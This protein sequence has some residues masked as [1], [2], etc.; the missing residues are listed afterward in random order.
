MASRGSGGSKRRDVDGRMGGDETDLLCWLRRGRG[1]WLGGTL[2]QRVRQGR[3]GVPG[4]ETFSMIY[5]STGEYSIKQFM[6]REE[7]G[8]P[9]LPSGRPGRIQHFVVEA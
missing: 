4:R 3:R 6:A 8:S 2:E 9:A 5:L 1:L 7:D